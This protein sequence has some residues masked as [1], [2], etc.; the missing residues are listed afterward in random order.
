[1]YKNKNPINKMKI[2]NT[3]SYLIIG[4]MTFSIGCIGYVISGGTNS[5]M[6]AIGP[7]EN[8]YILGIG[9]DTMPKYWLVVSFCFINSGM[10][11]FNLNVLHSWI[12]NEI[13]DANNISYINP[14][15]AYAISNIALIFYWYDFFMYMNI[16]FSQIDM[17]VVEVL[18]D[19]IATYILTRHY[20][21]LKSSVLP[22]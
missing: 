20:L 17:L 15:K 10:R 14:K 3:I 11:A 6:F 19:L 2:E 9:I 13:Q 4:W 7:N 21:S 18:S 5:H 8:F 12:I 1:V 16:L 22:I